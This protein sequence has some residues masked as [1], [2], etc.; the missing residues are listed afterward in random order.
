MRVI[1]KEIYDLG[2]SLPVGIDE[3]GRGPLA[4]PVV[5][6]AV[7]IPLG[8]H[9]ADVNDS[10][11]LSPKKREEL[12][13]EISL[14]AL[15]G[16]GTVSPAEIDEIN[17]FQATFLAMKRALD[18]LSAMPD[19]LLIDGKFALPGITTPQKALVKGDSRC[20]VVACASIIAKVTR[21][22]IMVKYD[23]QYPEYGFAQHKG[24]PTKAHKKAI[25]KYGP[26][27][28]HRCSFCGVKEG[29]AS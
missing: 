4:G 20:Y 11:L 10:K 28:I 13:E 8:I 26:T 9:I 23:S 15:I 19:F 17:I 5:A 16:V 22:R 12:F 27:P 24:Y 18:H 25:A 6:A 21:D 3:A 1:E 14:H 7:H 2:F 29:S